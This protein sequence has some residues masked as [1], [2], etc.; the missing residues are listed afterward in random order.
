MPEITSESNG[1]LTDRDLVVAFQSGDEAAYEEVYRRYAGRVRRICVRMLGNTQDADEAVQETFLKAYQALGRFNGSYQVGAWLAR[2]AANVCVDHVRFRARSARLVSWDSNHDTVRTERGPEELLAGSDPRLDTAIGNIQPLHAE[3]L[4]LRALGGFSHEEMAGKLSMTPAQVKALLHR[5]RTSF[6][7]AWDK[8][9][10]LSVLPLLGLRSLIGDR[11]QNAPAGT[12]LVESTSH[13]SPLFAER[14]A[15]SAVMVVVAL[16]GAPTVPTDSTDPSRVQEQ[17]R[18]FSEEPI[19]PERSA[20]LAQASAG[21]TTGAA[22][23]PRQAPTMVELVDE[24]PRLETEERPQRRH[25]HDD[26]GD[27][28]TPAGTGPY[29]KK[30]RQVAERVQQSFRLSPRR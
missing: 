8:A 5:A 7:R 12:K 2:I 18:M 19:R 17:A 10:A 30:A 15:A 14:V 24:A 11:S 13:L 26:D 9:E 3:A 27:G 23:Q 21:S 20:A 22:T 28:I 1:T 25:R 16:S 6:K 29:V 4:K